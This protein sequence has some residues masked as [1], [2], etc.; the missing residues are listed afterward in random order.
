MYFPQLGRELGVGVMAYWE[1]TVRVS[2][3]RTGVGY[4]ELTGYSGR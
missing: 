2:G 3:D 1:G 4:V